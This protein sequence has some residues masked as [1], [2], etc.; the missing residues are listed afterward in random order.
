[1]SNRKECIAMILAGGQGSR[2]LAL[3]KQI[4]K[5][6]V[7][8]GGKYR[9]I[10]FSL[11]NCANSGIT[12][13]GVL[14]QYRPYLLNNYIGNGA[15]WD[16]DVSAGGVFILPPYATE[17]GGQWYAGTADA[18]YQNQDFIDGFDPEYVLILSGDHLYSMDYREMLRTHVEKGADLTISV[19]RVPMEEASRF[20]IMSVNEDGRIVRFAEKPAQPESNL[21]SMGIYVFSA[22]VLKR[23]LKED[24]KNTSSDHDFGKN[25][26]PAMLAAGYGLYSYEFD[27]YWRDVGTIQ[28][29]YDT[30]MEFLAEEPPIDLSSKTAPIMSHE[31]PDPAQ[32]IGPQARLSN[33]VVA[34]GAQVFGRAERS[35]IG[36][37]AFVAEG[38][39][40][41]DSILLPG[42]SV[43]HGARV[44]RT[45]VG[46]G[47]VVEAG[48]S[49][50][51]LDG[52]I[53]VYA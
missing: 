53:T 23:V 32:F 26:I 29:Y 44:L 41:K 25:V 11:S 30:S 16:L 22:A 39:E 40:V 9:I 1:M 49:V 20:G 42:C 6:A 45:I 48:A 43:K 21:A 5:P 47:A 7:S 34:N 36:S 19:M 18:I 46:E 3:T 35:I 15:S 31:N 24:S 37:A 50:G 14:T 28:T 10:D 27:G 17:A 4:A 51:S 33:C 8:F 12:T 2:L 38:A 52:E 13:V